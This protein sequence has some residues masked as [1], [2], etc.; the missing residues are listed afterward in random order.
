MSRR[1]LLA[2]LFLACTFCVVTIA[3]AQTAARPATIAKPAAPAADLGSLAAPI[4]EEPSPTI[5]SLKGVGTANAVA[6]ARM[7]QQVLKE[8]CSANAS[9]TRARRSVWGS[10]RTRPSRQRRLCTAGRITTP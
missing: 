9:T 8:F 6:E 5:S 3:N 10:S 4:R 1:L 2:V 7:T